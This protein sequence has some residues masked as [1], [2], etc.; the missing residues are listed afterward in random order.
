M[1]ALIRLAALPVV[2]SCL[3]C[4]P[5]DTG[6]EAHT[7]SSVPVYALPARPN[8]PGN[9]VLVIIP[10]DRTVPVIKEELLKDFAAYRI[11]F[12]RSDGTEIIGYVLLGSDGLQIRRTSS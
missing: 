9:E 2:A 4:A 6:L 10:R 8:V 3:A 7:T 1:G 5:K 11:R 12:Q